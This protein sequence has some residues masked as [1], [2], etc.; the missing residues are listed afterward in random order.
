MAFSGSLMPLVQGETVKSLLARERRLPVR[1]ARR[2]LLEAAE[3]CRPPTRPAW[4]IATSS[5]KT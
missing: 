1:E 2:I 4:C 5:P 3:R